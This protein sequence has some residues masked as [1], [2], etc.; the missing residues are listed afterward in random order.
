MLGV[1]VDC[2]RNAVMSVS[3]VKEF[4]RLLRGMGYDT[5][6][7]YTEDT[8]TVENEP[9]FGYMR[10]RYTAEELTEIDEYCA[11]IGIEVIPCIQTLAHLNAVWQITNAYDKIRDLNDILL[12]DEERTYEFIDNIFLS[13]SK[14]FKSRKVHI[15]MDEADRVG[16]GKYLKKHG[17]TE[18]FDLINRHLHKVCEI[19][20]KYGFSPMLWS[21][22][23]CHLALQ[24]IDFESEE[25]IKEVQKKAALPENAT[26][27]YWDYYGTN[28][29]NYKKKIRLNRAFDRPVVFAGGAWCWKGFAPDNTLGIDCS[30][31]AIKA[32]AEENLEDKLITMWGD[33]GAECSRFAMLPVLMLFAEH[34]KGN[35]DLEDIKQKFKEL[36]GEDWDSFILLDQMDKIGGK[37]K[38][39]PSKYL[40]YNDMFTGLNDHRV[41]QTDGEYYK[42]I[43]DKLQSLSVGEKYKSIFD[44]QIALSRLL[45]V[46][47]PLGVK[48]RKAY[49]AGDKAALKELANN[50]YANA[51][52]LTEEF[53]DAFNLQWHKENKPFGFD[54]QDFRIGGV[55]QRLKACKQR[56]NDY[57]DGKVLEIPEL[58]IELLELENKLQ[59][60]NMATPNVISHILFP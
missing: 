16:L 44:T 42:S 30:T 38:Y 15:G 6:M 21:D 2:S 41:A 53:Y 13:L 48:T 27:V 20:G 35:T 43:A 46:K 31:A 19:A 56:L 12:I 28:I 51:I 23:F 34:S 57:C 50:D 18:R 47:A 37:H 59:W 49:N 33:D 45:A 5:L 11:N 3:A 24:N 7:L 14:C 9:F 25:S 52:E 26:L 8:F 1:M 36:I 10:G 22:M 54:I 32:C 17:V 55:I 29:E 39:N 58:E 60:S 4:A 40:L